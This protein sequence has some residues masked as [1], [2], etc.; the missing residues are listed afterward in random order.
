MLLFD[1]LLYVRGIEKGM[2]RIVAI[3]GEPSQTARDKR[4]MS[5]WPFGHA[6]CVTDPIADCGR[7][8]YISQFPTNTASLA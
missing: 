4:K 5:G 3:L 8:A 7:N 6:S 1:M 2:V